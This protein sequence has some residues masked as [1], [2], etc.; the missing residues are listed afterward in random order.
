MATFS[1]QPASQA[2]HDTLR[3]RLQTLESYIFRQVVLCT[4][5]EMRRGISEENG[6]QHNS[7]QLLLIFF[8]LRLALLT[9]SKSNIGPATHIHF[10]VV[11]I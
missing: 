2:G 4:G 6:E 8:I 7:A 11:V 9:V 10:T 5:I 3:L 1:L